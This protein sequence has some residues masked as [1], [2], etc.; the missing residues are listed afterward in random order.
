MSPFFRTIRL[1]IQQCVQFDFNVVWPPCFLIMAQ[2]LT[3]E[4]ERIGLAAGTANAQF[5]RS[6]FGYDDLKKRMINM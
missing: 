1:E 3:F 6:L 4:Q 5:P 2:I